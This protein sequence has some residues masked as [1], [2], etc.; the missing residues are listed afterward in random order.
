MFRTK[1]KPL[2]K[3]YHYVLFN[4]IK[5]RKQLHYI[6]LNCF[7]FYQ[8][9]LVDRIHKLGLKTHHIWCTKYFAVHFP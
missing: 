7:L 5:K 2:L 8:T 3:K 9:F 1:N 4:K 6:S